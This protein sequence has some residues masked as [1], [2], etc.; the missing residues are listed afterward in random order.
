MA[1]T[2]LKKIPQDFGFGV[3]KIS[4]SDKPQNLQ[5]ATLAAWSFTPDRTRPQLN[6]LSQT[7]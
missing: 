7:S 1:W 2:D 3:I 4:T 5:K 6:I